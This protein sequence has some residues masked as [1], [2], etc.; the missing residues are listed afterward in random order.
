MKSKDDIGFRRKR[1]LQWGEDN[2][3]QRLRNMWQGGG[4]MRKSISLSIQ[5]DINPA[6]M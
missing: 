2:D 4:R 3:F 1:A 5:K 6:A